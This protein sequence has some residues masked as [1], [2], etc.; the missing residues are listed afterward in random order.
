MS[1]AACGCIGVARRW[2]AA[3]ALPGSRHA[4][5]R[6]CAAWHADGVRPGQAVQA[7]SG[8]HSCANFQGPAW[9]AEPAVRGLPHLLPGKARTVNGEVGGRGGGAA[10]RRSGTPRRTPAPCVWPSAWPSAGPGW[11]GRGAGAMRLGAQ[12]A[13]SRARLPGRHARTSLQGS[14]K[15]EATRAGACGAVRCATCGLSAVGQRPRASPRVLGGRRSFNLICW[16]TWMTPGGSLRSGRP[17][18]PT[19][20]CK[21]RRSPAWPPGSRCWSGCAPARPGRAVPGCVPSGQGRVPAPGRRRRDGVGL[22]P[23]RCGR[24]APGARRAP[25]G[26][27]GRRIRPAVH[28]RQRQSVVWPNCRSHR[29]RQ[30]MERKDA[31][32]AST[33][34]CIWRVRASGNVHHNGNRSC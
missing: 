13:G 27:T 4:A 26:L 32:S 1:I 16:T 31:Q 30:L 22:G 3:P 7:H 14:A 11:G 17:A 15:A 34:E 28:E 19:A 8:S 6:V 21:P 18:I 12:M 33:Q 2:T 25:P 5:E 29:C 20:C 24:R 9:A 10:V 23:A